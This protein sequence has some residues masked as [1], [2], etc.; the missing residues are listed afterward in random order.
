MI[1]RFVVYEGRKYRVGAVAFKGNN[2]FSQ[3]EILKGVKVAGYP[4]R[5]KMVSGKVFTPQGLSKDVEAI[6]D[7]YGSK[8]YI[9]CV[10]IAVKNANTTTG[11]MD[12]VYEINEGEAARVEKIEIK[13][14]TKTK[15]KVIRREFAV[16]PGE[17]YDTVKV[18]LSKQRLEGLNYFE[19]VDTQPEDTEVL[20][21]KNLV[22]GVQEKNTGNF[23]IGA[24]FDSVQSVVGF[25][26]V[27]QGD[28]D[29]FHP[30]NFTGGGEKIRL[31]AS[32]GTLQRDYIVTF[33]EPWFLD[34]KLAFQVDLFDRDLN[35]V[36][37]NDLYDQTEVGARLGLTR[38]LGSD[39]LIGG[40]NYTIEQEG[41]F[42]NPTNGPIS[43]QLAQEA[44]HALLS[45]VGT[46]L[47]Y[48]TRNHAL[49]PNS[50]Q[51]TQITTDVVGGPFGGDDSYYKVELKTDWYFRGIWEG[52]ILQLSGKLATADTYDGT[53]RVP[54]F[55]RYFMGGLYDLR[56]YHYR[57]IGP[58]DSYGGG[59]GGDT[60]A[61]ATAEYTIPIV[62]RVKWAFFYDI[63]NVYA[64]SGP[65]STLGKPRTT[66]ASACGSICRLDRFGS[67]T[68]FPF[69]TPTM[70]AAPEGSILASDTAAR[71]NHTIP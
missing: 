25:A 40:I 53:T 48:D 71:F 62:E 19:K 38:T 9:D 18:K 24:G 64:G 1:L 29:L 65:S 46:L 69:G 26:E 45:R 59:I 60:Y 63:G 11:A 54:I 49:N 28:F 32:I 10:V 39:F 56:G 12:L 13:G 44:G 68:E 20:N 36:S 41:I 47:A 50:G 15:D 55:D 23:T 51:R 66:P 35:Y 57:T 27:S 31:R 30:P 33:V 37:P 7:Y 21:R 2:L 8:G 58:V 16:M 43:P 4:S 22:V 70:W 6:K 17:I 67:T 52:Q 5:V 3:A 61:F 14:N 42:L 34:Q